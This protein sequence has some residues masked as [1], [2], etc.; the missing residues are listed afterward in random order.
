MLTE[1][2][3]CCR[4]ERPAQTELWRSR[5]HARAASPAGVPACRATRRVILFDLTVSGSTII[6]VD[7]DA[8]RRYVVS[9]ADYSFG[10]LS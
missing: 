10:C 2:P 4:V 1:L 5:R 7:C 3:A 9:F 8:H 6:N